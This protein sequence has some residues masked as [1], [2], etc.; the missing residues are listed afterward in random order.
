VEYGEFGEVGRTGPT[1]LA[2]LVLEEIAIVLSEF[3]VESR[4]RAEH[5]GAVG[6]LTLDRFSQ[7]AS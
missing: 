3:E 1:F 7:L 2:L 5:S 4:R 6:A